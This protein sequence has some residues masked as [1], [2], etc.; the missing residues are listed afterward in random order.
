MEFQDNILEL[1]SRASNQLDHLQTEEA[2][3]MTLVIPFIRALGYDVFNPLEVVPEFTADVGTKKGEKVDYAIMKDGNPVMLFECKRADTKLTQEHG[4]QLYRYFS[5]TSAPVA[6]LTNGV[7]Y[8]FYSDVDERNKMD[9]KA[10]FVFSLLDPKKAHIKEL[11]QFSKTGFDPDRLSS[12]AADL[13]YS[14]EIQA[15][16]AEQLAEPSDDFLRFFIRRID[17]DKRVTKAVLQ[18][19]ARITKTA[20]SRF[21]RDRVSDRLESAL[22]QESASLETEPE[23]ETQAFPQLFDPTADPSEII[24]YQDGE[25]VTTQEEVNGYNVVKAIV[26]RVVDP[27]RVTIRDTKSYCGVLLDNNNRK[28]ICRLRFNRTKTKKIGIFDANKKETKHPIDNVDDIYSFADELRK[29]I[30]YYGEVPDLFAGEAKRIVDRGVVASPT[31]PSPIA[32][33]ENERHGISR[34]CRVCGFDPRELGEWHKCCTAD[35]CEVTANT[36]DEIESLFGFR[37]L[38]GRLVPQP[39]CKNHR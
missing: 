24:V 23:E 17:K 21:I 38:N 5:V 14:R 3:K 33:H 25:I 19:F 30:G 1:A 29:T 4:S 18:Q 16:F 11:E 7:K 36:E 37:N 28:P 12:V 6:V 2:A 34:S 13:K 20:L 10:F 39:R 8:H 31:K 26:A 22:T 27:K 35:G 32:D 9:R 15:I